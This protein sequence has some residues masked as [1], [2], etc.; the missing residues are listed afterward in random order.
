M[1]KTHS[2]INFFYQDFKTTA[3][4]IPQIGVQP[5]KKYDSID[6]KQIVYV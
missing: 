3:C 4:E 5:S 6:Y 2:T 1:L